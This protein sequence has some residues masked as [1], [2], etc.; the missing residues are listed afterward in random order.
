MIM[1]PQAHTR[2]LQMSHLRDARVG[3]IIATLHQLEQRHILVVDDDSVRGLF[4]ADQIS[5]Q[6]GRDVMDIEVPAHSVAEM[7]QTI[8]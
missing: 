2:V 3:H 5:L 8:G 7:L 6:L 1:T 4:A